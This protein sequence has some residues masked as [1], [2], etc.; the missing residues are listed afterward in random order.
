MEPTIVPIVL[1]ARPPVNV[2][3][4]ALTAAL[5]T[6]HATATLEADTTQRATAAVSV[7]ASGFAPTGKHEH[8]AQWAHRSLAI[9]RVMTPARSCSIPTLRPSRRRRHEHGAPPSD[10][11]CAGPHC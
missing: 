2:Q 10:K 7:V 1:T 5:G 6:F 11:G 4:I 8:F 9:D 3:E